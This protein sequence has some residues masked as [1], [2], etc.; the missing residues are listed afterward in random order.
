MKR[1]VCIVPKDMFS[2]AEIKQLEAGFKDIYTNNYSQEKVGVFWM[3][4]P[5]GY[6]YA[7]RKPSKAAIIL[8]EVNEDIQRE[9]REELMGLFSQFLMKNFHISPLDAVITVAN[10]S[11]V[12]QFSDAQQNRIDKRYRP[13]IKLKMMSTALTSKLINGYLRLRVKV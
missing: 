7:E 8:A 6:A 1:I 4:M 2:N 13:W 12:S 3:L 9:K 11:F 5:K 10:S